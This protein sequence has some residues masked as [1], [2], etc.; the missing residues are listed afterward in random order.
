MPGPAAAWT[1]RETG[2]EALR[3]IL[4]LYPPAFP[5]EDLRPL[6]TALIGEDGPRRLSLCTFGAG[7]DAPAAHLLFTLFAAGDA[8]GEAALLGPLCVHP[9]FQ[10]RGLGT[11]LVWHGLERL[12]GAGTAGVLVL[13]DPGYYARFGFRPERRVLPPCPLP[14]E[15]AEA[16]QSLP[17]AGKGPLPGGRC[18]LPDPWMDPGL[19]RP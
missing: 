13:G 6:V 2:G 12:R 7:S 19:W 8:V 11:A 15:W 9:R 5:E 18:H 17:L 16:W 10:R 1:I 14:E 3:A 4:S